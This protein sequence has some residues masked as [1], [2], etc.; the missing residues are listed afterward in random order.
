LQKN[1]LGSHTI[2]QASCRFFRTRIYNDNN[3]DS[4]FATSLQANCPTTGG[5]DNLSP[6]DTTTPNTFDNSYFQNLQSQKGLF[7]SD[8]ALFN[9][10]STDSDVDEYSSDSSSFATD[11]A[12]A[13]VKMGNLN[14]ITGSNG[15]IRTNCRVINWVLGPIGNIMQVNYGYSSF[16][17]CAIVY[18]YY[19]GKVKV[20]INVMCVWI[21][22]GFMSMF[23]TV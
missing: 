11:F 6:L 19:C 14:P 15:Q 12:N 13:M 23:A 16:L 1:I 22:Y 17:R 20:S 8:Q 18:Y 21:L 10:G 3:I 5:D 2:G 4:T 7:S 9:G